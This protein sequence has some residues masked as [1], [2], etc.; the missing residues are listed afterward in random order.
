VL[1]LYTPRAAAEVLAVRES[2]LRR[3]AAARAV[4]CTF[5]GRHLRFSRADLEAIAQAAAHPPL[6][7]P[8]AQPRRELDPAPEAVEG[9]DDFQVSVGVGRTPR[10]GSAPRPRRR[11]GPNKASRQRQAAA[12]ADDRL[13]E[14]GRAA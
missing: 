11:R 4:P 6:T 12:A 14:Q 13:D 9:D 10:S 5:L 7:A 2:W 1:P 8:E 3:K